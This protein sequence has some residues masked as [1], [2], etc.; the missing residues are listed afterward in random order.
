[1][2]QTEQNAFRKREKKNHEK[3][4]QK[5]ALKHK[6]D[7]CVKQNREDKHTHLIFKLT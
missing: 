7:P 5:I 6:N 3:S 4:I 1:M 2:F